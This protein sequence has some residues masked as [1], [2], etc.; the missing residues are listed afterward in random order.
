LAIANS[1]QRDALLSMGWTNDAINTMGQ[2]LLEDIYADYSRGIMRPPTTALREPEDVAIETFLTGV[3]EDV[4]AAAE[5]IREA[6]S[7]LLDIS[8]LIVGGAVL[9]AVFLLLR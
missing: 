3:Q 9:L 8:P 5:G 2:S 1:V 6:G 4:I 7:E